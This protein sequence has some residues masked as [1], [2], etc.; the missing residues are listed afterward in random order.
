[1]RRDY[2]ICTFLLCI[3][4]S[5]FY[6]CFSPL[7]F[8]YGG[9]VPRS[10]GVVE[11]IFAWINLLLVF[12]LLPAYSAL[13]KK[14]WVTLGLATYSF[15]CACLPA[16]IL[17]GMEASIAGENANILSVIW[18]FC[19]KSV[20]G[21]A[22]AP[23]APISR[24]FGNKFAE[25]LPRRILPEILIV[26]CVVQLYRFY[27]D[28]YIAE[29]LNPATAIDTTAKEH[30]EKIEEGIRKTNIE[31]EILGT[32]ISAPV[33]PAPAPDVAPKP[34]P[35]PV[36]PKPSRPAKPAH[37]G[38]KPLPKPVPIKVIPQVPPKEA[39]TMVQTTVH[40]PPMPKPVRLPDDPKKS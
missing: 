2:F 10:F 6:V 30:K 38:S 29:K 12:V 18:G 5:L 23:F 4:V 11:T 39:P 37:S 13:L 8:V 7:Y 24:A 26:Y 36:P 22:E 33:K 25:A 31:P 17:P 9:I 27:K 40:K 28:A 34:A 32:V 15:V 3:C 35:V 16:W 20:Y 1:M 19:L 21:M 14:F